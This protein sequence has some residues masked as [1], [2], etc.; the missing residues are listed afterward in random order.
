MKL[1]LIRHG[2]TDWNL[3]GKIQ[4]SYDRAYFSSNL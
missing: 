1:F 3:K 4:G 2:Q